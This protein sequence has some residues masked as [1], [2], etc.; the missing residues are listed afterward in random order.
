MVDGLGLHLRSNGTPF[1]ATQTLAL[2]F[3]VSPPFAELFRERSLLPITMTQTSPNG[4]GFIV[5]DK[6]KGYANYPQ[7]VTF[8]YSRSLCAF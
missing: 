1:P 7:Y 2:P 6:A 4:V 3:P 5:G 8:A